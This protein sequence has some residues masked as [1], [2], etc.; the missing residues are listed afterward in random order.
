VEILRTLGDPTPR[1]TLAAA[2]LATDAAPV[3]SQEG[4]GSL[5]DTRPTL[6]ARLAALEP[7]EPL[8]PASVVEGETTAK[9]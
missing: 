1:R 6:R 9:R 3:K 4:S 8:E 5:L 2:M 7:L